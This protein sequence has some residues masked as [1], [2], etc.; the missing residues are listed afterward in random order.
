MHYLT[1]EI[2]QNEQKN[3]CINSLTPKKIGYSDLMIHVL[4][5]KSV[6]AVQ[7][8]QGKC[9]KFL[10]TKSRPFKKACGITVI[11]IPE[12]QHGHQKLILGQ[13]KRRFQT[14]KKNTTRT[15]L[16]F[17]RVYFY[18]SPSVERFWDGFSR[19]LSVVLPAHRS[20]PLKP[21]TTTSPL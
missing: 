21:S 15:R 16:N 5:G 18:P 13:K 6:D 8:P 1:G 14:C 11:Y 9:P 7:F 19:F 12:N 2:P 20:D 17:T 3:I 4:M 10:T